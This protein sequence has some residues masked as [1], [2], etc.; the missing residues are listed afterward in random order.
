M[1]KVS[2]AG[3]LILK[4]SQKLK[5]EYLKSQIEFFFERNDTPGVSPSLLGETVKAFLRGC[6]ISYH[7]TQNKRRKAEQIELEKQIKQLDIE[8]AAYPSIEKQQNICTQIQ[9]INQILSARISRAFQFTKQ[10]QFEFGDKPHKPLARQLCKLENDRMIHKIR[11]EK[12]E[13]LS[14]PKDINERFQQFYETLYSSQST[15]DPVTMQTFFGKCNLPTLSEMERKEL[16]SEITVKDIS[17]TIKS[18]KSGKNTWP[19]WAQQ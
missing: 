5:S 8:N 19:R 7:T 16:G 18:L 4:C 10:K 15:V 1:G 3:D 2:R 14:L 9:T 6:I 11:S 17:E 12:G 13:L